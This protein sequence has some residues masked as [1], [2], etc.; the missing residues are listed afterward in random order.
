MHDFLRIAVFCRRVHDLEGFHLV[1]GDFGDAS[2]PKAAMRLVGVTAMEQNNWPVTPF[3]NVS[4][5][6]VVSSEL[7]ARREMTQ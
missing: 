4:M 6:F 5:T 1:M 7:Q 2:V 3:A